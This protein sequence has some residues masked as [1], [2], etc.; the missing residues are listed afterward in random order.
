MYPRSNVGGSKLKNLYYYRRY[1]L[2]TK[3]FV[4]SAV[5]LNYEIGSSKLFAP[6]VWIIIQSLI[7]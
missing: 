1:F 6:R 3:A 7:I 4:Q 5:K 2:V